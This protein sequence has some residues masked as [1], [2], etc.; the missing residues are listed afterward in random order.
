MV[1]LL[2]SPGAIL[3]PLLGKTLFMNIAPFKVCELI[4]VPT[5]DLNLKTIETLGF[6]FTLN[7]QKDKTNEIF[8]FRFELSLKTSVGE[9]WA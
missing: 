6:R 8:K 9:L 5:C 3:G 7:V 2:E 1:K 4:I